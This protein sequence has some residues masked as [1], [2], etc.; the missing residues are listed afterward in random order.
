EKMEKLRVD[1]VAASITHY[2]KQHGGKMA[3]TDKSSPT[4]ILNTF[5]CSKKDFK[6]ALGLLYKQRV[7]ALGANETRLV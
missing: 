6:K 7:V 5:N 2:L 1:D 3:L 4:E